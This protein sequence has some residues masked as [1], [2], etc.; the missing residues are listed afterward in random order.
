MKHQIEGSGEFRHV[1]HLS[2]ARGCS[3]EF[4]YNITPSVAR[5][6]QPLADAFGFTLD[7]FLDA[8]HGEFPEQPLRIEGV[9]TITAHF[10]APETLHL[11]EHMA[12][13]REL[14]VSEYVTAAVATF[15]EEDTDEVIFRPG[16][17]EVLCERG[18][19]APSEI[20]QHPS[21]ASS[22]G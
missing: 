18:I 1:V 2:D 12:A 13:R 7:Q 17:T 16:T 22:A 10:S 5:M 8:K 6:L 21:H 3:V 9:G 15:L 11:V 4:R 19:I 20:V 14:T